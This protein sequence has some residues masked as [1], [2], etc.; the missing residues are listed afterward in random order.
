MFEMI[1]EG[2]LLDKNEIHNLEKKLNVEL[3]IQ[4]KSFLEKFNGGKPLQSEVDFTLPDGTDSGDKIKRFY[5]ASIDTSYG[6]RSNHEDLSWQLPLGYLT[7]AI[8]PA[9]NYFLIGLTQ[10]NYGQ[11]F[12][13]DHELEDEPEKDDGLP[14]NMVKVANSFNEFLDKLYDPDE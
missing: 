13:K 9:G 7:I 3:P 10:N 4:Y 11:I 14:Y 8:T 12:Y 6:L 2:P 5:E 1:K